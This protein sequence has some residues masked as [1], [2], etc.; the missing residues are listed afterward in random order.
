MKKILYFFLI[1]CIS[2]KSY[3]T[4]FT[5]YERHLP[6][7]AVDK[8]LKDSKAEEEQYSLLLF[9]QFFNGEEF[10]V[11]NDDKILL[12]ESLQTIKNFGLAKV[13]RINN[14]YDVKIK[15]IDMNIK[16]L[17]KSNLAKKHK[18]IYIE[19]NK[20]LKDGV[21]NDSISNT[22]KIYRII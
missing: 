4:E 13:I 19:K 3:Q 14:N 11:K 7:H 22:K 12:K 20:Y 9:T 2:C 18:F 10:I 8:I 5:E 1:F 16:V 21:G 17:V 6:K 15:D